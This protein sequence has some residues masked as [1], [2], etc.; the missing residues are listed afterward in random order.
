L[1]GYL[2]FETLLTHKVEIKKSYKKFPFLLKKYS[3]SYEYSSSLL[4]YPYKYPKTKKLKYAG[5]APLYSTNFLSNYQSRLGQSMDGENFQFSDL[6]YNRAEVDQIAEMMT[7]SR[8]I[9]PLATES[10]FKKEAPKFDILHLAMHGFTHEERPLESG[11]I[12]SPQTDSLNDG[13]LHAHELYGMKLRAKLAILSACHTGSGKLARG[14]G[15]MSL[16]RAFKYAGCPNVISTLWQADD[17]STQELIHSFFTSVAREENM[18][19]ALRKAKL[20]FLEEANEIQAHPAHWAAFIYIGDPEALEL[21][22]K[23]TPI[24]LLLIL[25]LFGLGFFYLV[26]FRKS[27]PHK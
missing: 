2:P 8:Y 4:L 10:S 3:L 19:T 1:L 7:G 24:P 21:K 18:A 22:A 16:S 14:E 26:F 13:I 25:V 12:F 23:K 5:F 20:K 27:F 11:L 6:R 17:K 15:I 9:G